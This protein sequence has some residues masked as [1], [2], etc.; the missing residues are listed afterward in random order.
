MKILAFDTAT[1]YCSAALWLDGDVLERSALAGRTHSQLLLPQCQS[2]LAETEMNL[3]QLDGIAFGM[4]P[5]SFTGLRI[6]CAVAQGLAFAAGLPVIGISSLQAMAASSGGDKA[7]V[8]LDARMEEVYHAVYARQSETWVELRAPA[9][10]RPEL[11]PYPAGEGWTGCGSGFA[12]YAEVLLS[13]FGES[14]SGVVADCYP[15]AG[16]IAQLAAGQF[17]QGNGY[18]AELAAPLYIRNKVALKICER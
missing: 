11:V 14:L 4:G 10:C 15:Y 7:L 16:Q 9:V 17:E 3:G 13:R 8:C 12:T 1:E 2:L 5:G 6:G 18:A